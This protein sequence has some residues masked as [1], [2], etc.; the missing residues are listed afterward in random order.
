MHSSRQSWIQ[1]LDVRLLRQLP[2]RRRRMFLRDPCHPYHRHQFQFRRHCLDPCLRH[3][4]QDLDLVRNHFD[5]LY[6]AQNL[7]LDFHQF[8]RP[9]NFHKCRVIFQ[10]PIDEIVL[11][12]IARLR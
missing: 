3:L 12:L 4:R 10:P 9:L 2:Y 1:Y 6:L 5:L 11:W 7:V 8:L